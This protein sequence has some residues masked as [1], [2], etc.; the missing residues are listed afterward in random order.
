MVSKDS[1]IFFECFGVDGLI[2]S[3]LLRNSA[4]Q[5]DEKTKTITITDQP[6]LLNPDK[7]DAGKMELSSSQSDPYLWIKLK[8]GKG[9]VASEKI[10]FDTGDDAFYRLSIN[11]YKHITKDVNVFE[12]KAKSTGSFTAGIHGIAEDA[13]NYM[14]NIPLI[15]VNEMKFKNVT[16]KTSYTDASRFGSG[17]LKYGKITLDYIN[18]KFYIQPFQNNA[19]INLQKQEWPI[20]P[21]LQNDKL[22]IGIVWDQ[23]LYKNIK[24]GDEIIKFD[25]LDYQKMNFCDII[26]SNKEI[27]KPKA[28]IELKD[29]QTGQIKE[30][31]I[32]KY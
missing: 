31:E 19:E 29:A 27:D 13:E 10:L 7:N 8:N 9:G 5:F 16:T 24:R 15:E 4:I 17:I 18:K 11:A 20:D 30:V 6:N 26:K 32:N 14:I 3:N 28:I 25:N 1:Q 22:V 12:I 21:I 2:G 23:S